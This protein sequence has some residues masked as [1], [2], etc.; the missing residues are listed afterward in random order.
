MAQDGI[1]ASDRATTMRL[2]RPTSVTDDF[3]R[4]TSPGAKDEGSA[5][6]G[7]TEAAVD[8]ADGC[9]PRGRFAN[10]QPKR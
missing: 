6:T 8:L 1:S 2:I 7:H 4:P 9:N 3:T 5:P 10:R